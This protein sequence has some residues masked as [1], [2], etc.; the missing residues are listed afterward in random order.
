M[1]IVVFK[2]ASDDRHFKGGCLRTL[3]K[4]KVK[5]KNVPLV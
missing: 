2:F 1:K 5:V 3:A 4:A